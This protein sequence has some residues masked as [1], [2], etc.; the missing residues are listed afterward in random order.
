[1]SVSTCIFGWSGFLGR[2]VVRRVR[3]D[4]AAPLLVGRVARPGVEE[5][6]FVPCDVRDDAE[7][8]TLLEKHL[9]ER[10]INCAALSRATDC[11]RDPELA[12]E[13]NGRFPGVLGDLCAR[14]DLRL[15]HVSTDLVF[16]GN[17]PIGG[18][19]EDDEPGPLN[20]YGSTK[21]DGEMACSAANESA[22]IVRLP[23]LFG[24]S[25]G[26]ALGASDSLLDAV[27][28]GDSQQLFTD[29][30]R[31][32][33]DVSEAAAALVELAHTSANGVLHVAGTER[34]SRYELGRAVLE[35]ANITDDDLRA[36][37]RADLGL[38]KS[39]AEDVSLC[40]KRSRAWLERKPSRIEDALARVY[41]ND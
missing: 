2:H 15:V 17:A 13:T 21:V 11:D 36:A 40:T 30:W 31:T 5:G 18:Y 41:R 27:R 37:T 22:L 20:L 6:T 4:G 32:P 16:S 24:D 26:R 38:A 28:R 9:P 7:L 1:M 10:V 35:A 19:E 12:R 33:L 29:E 34:L 23:L 8:A 3:E 39:R 25:L 14:L